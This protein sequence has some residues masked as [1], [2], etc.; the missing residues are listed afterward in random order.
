MAAALRPTDPALLHYRSGAFYCLRAAQAAGS[1]PDGDGAVVG[2]SGGD[3]AAGSFP[4][5]DGAV[6]GFPMG[7]AWL[8][9]LPAGTARRRSVTR[10]ANVTSMTA[11]T[12]RPVIATAP[13]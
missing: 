13:A 9:A 4:D 11:P 7:T 10:T 5:G 3:G 12:R 8:S 1:F 2:L 6:G